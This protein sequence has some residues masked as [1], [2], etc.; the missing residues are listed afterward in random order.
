[1][2]LERIKMIPEFIKAWDSRKH[3]LEAAFQEKHPDY[4]DIVKAVVGILDR[5]NEYRYPDVER[6]HEIDDGNYQ[7]VLVYVIGSNG[8]QPDEYWYVKVAYGSCSGCDTLEGIMSDYESNPDGTPSSEQIK[9][10][11]TLALHIIQNIKKMDDY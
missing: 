9:D 6:I 3:E 5:T 1:M 2:I 8:Y 11:M 7:G 4:I 10:Y